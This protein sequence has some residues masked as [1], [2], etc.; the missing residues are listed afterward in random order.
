MTITRFLAAAA[1]I[2]GMA[3]PALAQ[4]PQQYPQTYP[5]QAYPQTYPQN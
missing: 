2:G 3:A 5:Q 4:Y 1:A